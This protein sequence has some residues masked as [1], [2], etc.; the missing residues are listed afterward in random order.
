MPATARQA[1]AIADGVTA[2]RAC[3][4]VDQETLWHAFAGAAF[5]DDFAGSWL[6]LQCARIAGTRVALVLFEDADSTSLAP[7]AAWPAQADFSPLQQVAERAMAA[8]E[9]VVDRAGNDAI[10]RVAYP[11]EI[12]GHVCGLVLLEL[13]AD[14]AGV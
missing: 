5:G 11:I 9:G 1:D 13:T 14:D 4:A 8:G 7:I 3:P 10:V 6:A 12:D 2:D